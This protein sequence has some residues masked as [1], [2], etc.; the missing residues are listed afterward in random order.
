MIIN[1]VAGGQISP[2]PMD[3]DRRHYN[4]RTTVRVCDIYTVSQKTRH[5]TLGQLH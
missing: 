3:F 1:M 2:F 4:T 5:Q